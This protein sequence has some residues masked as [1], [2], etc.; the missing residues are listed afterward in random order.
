M[1]SHF[2]TMAA[3]NAWANARLYEAALALSEE[4]YRRDV[5]AFFKSLHGTLNHLLVTDRIWLGRLAGESDGSYK[6]DAI[7]FDDR[8]E[9]TRARLVEDA[10][11]VRAVGDIA[12]DQFAGEQRYTR[13]TGEVFSQRRS[14]MLAHLF[15]HQTHHRGH[16]HMILSLVTGREPS[17]FDLLLMQRGVQAPDLQQVIARA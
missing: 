11:L 6:L 1:K 17:S 14:D 12:A 5:G 3:Y 4:D 8:L 7:L 16:A 9:L 10:R 2:E 15:N 13:R